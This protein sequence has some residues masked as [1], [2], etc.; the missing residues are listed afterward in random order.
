[1]VIKK[2][3]SST[4]PLRFTIKISIQFGILLI[5][6]LGEGYLKNEI[7]I[8]HF[9][10]NLIKLKSVLSIL[11]NR[12]IDEPLDINK[13]LFLLIAMGGNNECLEVK[14]HDVANIIWLKD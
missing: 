11:L 12:Y 5:G 4:N 8:L 9:Y 10:F 7:P 1:M 14:S 6:F 3:T 2:K 13:S